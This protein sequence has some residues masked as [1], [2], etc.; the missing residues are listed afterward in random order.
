[1]THLTYDFVF[2][3]LPLAAALQGPWSRL[4][5]W[6]IVLIAFFGLTVKYISVYPDT[7]L[8]MVET[9]AG[10]TIVAVILVAVSSRS[11]SRPALDG[12]TP[13]A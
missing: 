8:F 7:P 12:T 13:A 11:F 1:M 6:V 2:L 10:S 5:A 9:L 4:R 3:A